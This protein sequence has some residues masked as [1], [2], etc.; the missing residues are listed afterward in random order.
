MKQSNNTNSEKFDNMMTP[1]IMQNHKNNYMSVDE[2]RRI[3]NDLGALYV[4]PRYLHS[5]AA[6]IYA[7]EQSWYDPSNKTDS[8]KGHD[9]ILKYLVLSD[10][11]EI[12]DLC[13]KVRKELDDKGWLVVPCNIE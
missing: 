9:E 3:I 2:A 13:A 10:E 8:E 6:E 4:E 7:D 5:M 11:N 1:E 12:E